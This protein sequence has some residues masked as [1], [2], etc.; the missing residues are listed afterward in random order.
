MS[1]KID[2][3]SL[4]KEELYELT[5][6]FAKNWLAH[7]GCWFL[8]IEKEKGMDLAIEMDRQA[9]Q[10][11]TVAEAKRIMKFLDLPVNSGISGLA[12]ALKFRMYSLL[13]EDM[14]EILDEK[15]LRYWVK[16]CRVQQT[17]RRKNLPDFPCKSV[18][19]VEYS[20][21]A[22]TIDDRFETE[23]ISCPPEITNNDYYCIWEFILNS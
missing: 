1:E 6:N 3:Q 22:K 19:I 21:F 7:D 2:I 4:D 11:F 12:R 9:W 13:N 15:I 5:Q 10:M 23:C 8:A 17:R 18:G 14:V 16:T 20:F